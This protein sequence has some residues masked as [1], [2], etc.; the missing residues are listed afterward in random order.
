MTPYKPYKMNC[1]IKDKDG[2][3]LEEHTRNVYV[4][5]RPT[6]LDENGAPIRM[7]LDA[8]C[9]TNGRYAVGKITIE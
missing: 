1:R 5:D 8:K 6:M 3:V 4:V 7:A 2:K 9:E